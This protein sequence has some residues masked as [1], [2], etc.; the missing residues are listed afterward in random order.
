MVSAR[1][2]REG[3]RVLKARRIPERRIAALIGLSRSGMRYRVR[4]K[5]QDCLAERIQA[6]SSEHPRYGQVRIWALLRR[7]DIVVNHKAVSRL[8]QKLGLQLTRRPKRRKVRS[9][10]G[11][12]RAAEFPNHVWTYDFVFAWTLGGSALKFL[13]LEDEYTRECLAIEVGRSFRALHVKEV[14]ARVIAQR[15]V[16]KFIRSDNGPEFVSLEIGLWLKEQG[17][18]T[19]LIDPGKPWQNGLAESFNARFRDECLKGES[20][21][22]V[23]EARVIAQAFMRSFNEGHPHSS[24]GFHTPSEFADLCAMGA[25]PPNPRDLSPWATPGNQRRAG[26][27]Q[28]PPSGG[29]GSALRSL[30]SVA[31]SSVQA[32]ETLP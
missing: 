10:D 18:D 9:G 12:P 30:P 13:T 25:L 3:A 14:L 19:H 23:P 5:P 1:Q 7:A 29:P 11:V 28:P 15:G 26:M 21:H 20:F 22:G 2:K 31:L 27:S 6:L 24:L 16:P 4:P 17:V 8:W 32:E